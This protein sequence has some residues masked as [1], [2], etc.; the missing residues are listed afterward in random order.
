MWEGI[1]LPV[2]IPLER[3]DVDH[4]TGAS[5]E[6]IQTN[7]LRFAALADDTDLFDAASFR[8]A[9][10]EAAAI[11]PQQRIL[12]EQAYSALQVCS[13]I[14]SQSNYDSHSTRISSTVSVSMSSRHIISD[15]SMHAAF[16]SGDHRMREDIIRR[17]SHA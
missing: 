11:D 4:G 16:A 15:Q 2:S 10:A 8:I 12:L 9:P 14:N 5:V 3:W 17:C 6:I 1:D 7:M 13:P